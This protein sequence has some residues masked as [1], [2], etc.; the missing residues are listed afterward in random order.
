VVL[1]VV[2]IAG[3]AGLLAQTKESCW[4][5]GDCAHQSPRPSAASQP[6]AAL[7]SCPACCN[8]QTVVCGK[9]LNEVAF[10]TSHN[11]MSSK[12]EHWL[13]PNNIFTMEDALASG[14][15]G[16]MLDVFYHWPENS[17]SAE[18][19]RPTPVYLCHGFCS[20]GHHRARDSFLAIKRFLDDNPREIVVLIF[21]QY[22][23][24]SSLI[25]EL[26]ATHLT[27]YTRYGHQGLSSPWPT[28]QELLDNN[29]KLFVFSNRARTYTGTTWNRKSSMPESN[30]PPNWRSTVNVAWWHYLNDHRSETSY[31]YD[32]VKRMDSDCDFKYGLA[33]AKNHGLNYSLTI[34]NHF[35]SNPLPSLELARKANAAGSLLER[36]QRCR[37]SWGRQVN[38]PT[39]DFWSVGDLIDTV[40][41]LNENA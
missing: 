39:V 20:I 32:N 4:E 22:V 5:A 16:F 10:A 23:A 7:Q 9:P 24:T 1:H 3:M 8:L 6:P 33:R 21:E 34:A 17:T 14:I 30:L 37:S 2:L 40:R 36:M 35:I 27:T 26:Q 25:E 13:F 11:A 31:A 18:R 15:R 19:E 41:F 12:V 28:V 38:F 29:S